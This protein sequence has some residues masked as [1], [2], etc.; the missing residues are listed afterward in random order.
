M[1]TM[2]EW[3]SK[4]CPFCQGEPLYPCVETEEAWWLVCH[5][6]GVRWAVTRWDISCSPRREQV[7]R[8]WK[9]TWAD[10]ERLVEICGDCEAV[11]DPPL[12]GVRCLE[13]GRP[14]CPA[15]GANCH[16]VLHH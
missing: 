16:P 3:E 12:Q 11:R 7:E 9:R 6:H 5:E 13:C 15:C 10:L 2:F 4:A 14:I 1:E 8:R